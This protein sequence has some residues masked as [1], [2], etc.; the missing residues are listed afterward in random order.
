MAQLVTPVVA[1]GTMASLKQPTILTEVY[2][3]RPWCL[4]DASLLVSAF[5]DPTIRR[6]HTNVVED[7]DEAIK[8]ITGWERRWESETD[9]CWAI[10]DARGDVVI[11]RVALR[12]VNLISGEA[13]ISYWNLPEHRN[14]GVCTSAVQS[15]VHW[16]FNELGLHRLLLRHAITNEASCRVA[17]KA[18]FEY[19]GTLIS[20][21]KLV[22]G[23]HD[24]HLHA[25][26][27]SN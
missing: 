8:W 19:E 7:H 11:G 16:S 10:T 24:M 22:D 4:E 20:A 13:E 12:D 25:R 9:A 15:L 6:W 26:I 1:A 23:W 27:N 3:L 2:Q 14:R 17:V 21:Q 18:G 5:E